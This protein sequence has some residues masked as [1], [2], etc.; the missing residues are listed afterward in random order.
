MKLRR[1]SAESGDSSGPKGKFKKVS[2]GRTRIEIPSGLKIV[3]WADEQRDSH[4]S[5]PQHTPFYLPETL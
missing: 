1:E 3:I 2:A 5:S 4:D